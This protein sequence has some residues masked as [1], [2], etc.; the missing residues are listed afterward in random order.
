M[1]IK[2]CGVTTEA[3]AQMAVDAGATAL[4]FNFYPKSPRYL[5][6]Q[7][8]DWVRSVKTLKVG[9]FV[10]AEPDWV[11]SV[12]E[13]LD[14]DV[15]Q[16]HRG[17][18]PAGLRVWQAVAIDETK[19]IGVPTDCEALVVDAPPLT[20]DMPGGTGQTYDWRRAAHLPGKI[21]LAGGLSGDNVAEAI[22]QA[23]PWGVDAASRLES[24]PGRKDPAKV[25]SF[26]L[27]AMRAFK[28]WEMPA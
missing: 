26:V 7:A 12:K 8:A 4:G 9:V 6:V 19:P 27:E 14:L 13:R 5:P 20:A 15:V 24:A 28:E 2:V 16:I 18:A 23:R 21:I 10:D 17:A 22:R 11:R 1:L 3:D 25:A